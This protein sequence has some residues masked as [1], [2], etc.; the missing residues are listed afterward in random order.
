MKAVRSSL[1]PVLKP[2][3]RLSKRFIVY[4]NGTSFETSEVP[5]SNKHSY[6]RIAYNLIHESFSI[7]K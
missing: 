5:K 1:F 6:T 3:H 2:R 4:E 7:H